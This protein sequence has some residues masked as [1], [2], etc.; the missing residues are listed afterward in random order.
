MRNLLPRAMTVVLALPLAAAALVACAYRYGVEDQAQYLVQ[1]YALRDPALYPDDPYLGAFGSLGSLFWYL[2]QPVP[3]AADAWV[4][5]T[6]QF[7]IASLNAVLLAILVRPLLP[8]LPVRASGRRVALL[9]ASVLPAALLVVPK[10]LNWFGLVSLAD[11]EL[12]GTFAVLPVALA[13]VV[14]YTRSRPWAALAC[15]ALAIPIHGQTGVFLCA[16]WNLAMLSESWADLPRR[17]GLLA[18]GLAGG[19]AAGWMTIRSRLPEDLMP[20]YRAAGDGLYPELIDPIS[21]TL[22]SWGVVGSLLLLGVLAAWHLRGLTLPGAPLRSGRAYSR[23]LRWILAS[24]VLPSA[25]LLLHG[26]GVEEPFLFKLMIG[27]SLMLAQIGATVLIAAWAAHTLVRSEPV[28]WGLAAVVLLL[29]ALW[30]MPEWSVV[31]AGLAI[32]GLLLTVLRVSPDNRIPGPDAV[33]RLAGVSLA[34]VVALL[35]RLSEAPDHPWLESAEDP[36]WLAVQRWA[37]AHT[38]VEAQFVTPPYLSG[39]RVGSQRGTF[40]EVKDGCLLFY[41]GEPVLEW[42]ERMRSLG[43]TA[44]YAFVEVDGF[45]GAAANHGPAP[46]LR[47]LQLAYAD[48]IAGGV[49][50][51]VDF[52]VLERVDDHDPDPPVFSNDRFVVRSRSDHTSDRSTARTGLASNPTSASGSAISSYTPASTAER[53]SPSIIAIP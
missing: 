46:S 49:A 42:A 43:Q 37:R 5:L 2:F 23:L 20:A 53:S 26:I 16:A 11:R 9:L 41:A 30:P 17:L 10:E 1:L 18:F 22:P 12:T 19:A 13:S 35:I 7:V 29:I 47:A 39:W 34:V 28:A 48:A 3:H 31:G 51:T 32:V 50:G 14:F 38:P 27:R 21:A 8:V 40:G 24:L 45:A 25:G 44:P 6:L 15:S 52:M 4:F 33:A 36:Q